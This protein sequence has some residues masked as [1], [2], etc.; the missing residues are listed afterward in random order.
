VPLP[1]NC[2]F[3]RALHIPLVV[4]V[5]DM[6][7]RLFPEY[8]EHHNIEL[9]EKGMQL[10]S[11]RADRVI[12]VSASSRQDLLEAYPLL[13]G[14]VD[15]VHEAA[16]ADRFG[17]RGDDRQWQE[18]RERY[19]IPDRPFFLSLSTLE[20]RKN[21]RNILAAFQ[22]MVLSRG[23]AHT[24]LVVC[25][26]KGWKHEVMVDPNH[27]VAQQILF[28]GHV[29]DDDLP[30][31]FSYAKA[32]C[33]IPHYEGFGLPPLE[34]MRCG[35]PVIYGNNSAMPEVVG[36]AGVPVDSHDVEAIAAAMALLADD[37]DLRQKLADTAYV[38]ARHFSWLKTAFQT[39]N[40]YEEVIEQHATPP[41][42]ANPLDPKASSCD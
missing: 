3:A 24:L 37:E 40:V 34:A 21:L 13:Q 38:R 15:V 23:D 27:P 6:T 41:K 5:H 35:L 8:H 4:T 17:R 33:Y 9:T 16:N 2:H 25:G 18:V 20:P 28:T 1:Q 10:L 42:S 39:L 30:W 36:K 12:A 31:F 7:H 29:L 26:R 32:L 22:Q 14:Q 11:E 19:Q